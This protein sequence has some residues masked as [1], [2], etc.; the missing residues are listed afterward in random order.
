MPGYTVVN[1]KEVEDMAPRFDLSPQLEARFA[2]RRLELDRS[3]ISYQALSPGFR[4]PFGHKHATQEEIYVV[5]RGGAR[6]K[7]DDDVVELKQWDAV[8]IP[9][10]TMRGIEAGDDGL[11]LIAFGAP[12]SA[13]AQNDA[14]MVPGWWAEG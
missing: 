11:E 14:E 12:T 5:V 2:R 4:V 9:A 6:M 1:L 10:D 3:G 8:R 7:L 13:S